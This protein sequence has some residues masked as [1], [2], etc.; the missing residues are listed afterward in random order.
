[1]SYSPA[2]Y[3]QEKDIG[4]R[5]PNGA[6]L[7]TKLSG[8]HLRIINFHMS[9]MT[10]IQIAQ[11]MG[12]TGAQISIILNDPLSKQAIRERFVEVDNEMYAKS[13]QVVA[14]RLNSK[15]ESLSLRAAEMVWRAR[16][17][18]EKKE[19]D[20][21]TA[22]DLVR[23]MLEIAGSSGQASLTVTTGTIPASADPA[24]GMGTDAPLLLE[25]DP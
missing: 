11:V 10:G 12:M 13:H 7:L 16:G 9:G 20:R 25:N 14:D 1:M 17:R 18:F 5:Q 8:K 3:Q 19:S 15:D 6:K 24:L 2:L 22:E 21:P 23:R 4:L